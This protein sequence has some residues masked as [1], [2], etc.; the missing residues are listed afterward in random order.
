MAV[1][2]TVLIVDD[3]LFVRVLLRD[4]LEETGLPVIEASDGVEAVALAASEK[5]VCVFLDLFMP[6]K[7][8]LE[9]LAEIRQASPESRIMVLTGMDSRG[10][11]ELALQAGAVDFIAKP[12]HRLEVVAALERALQA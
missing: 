11:E 10:M 7:S 8:G 1:A 2:P 3:D 4:A 9:A 6:R 12:F 5:P